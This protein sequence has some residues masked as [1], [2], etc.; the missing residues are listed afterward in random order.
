MRREVG[1]QLTSEPPPEGTDIKF[2]LYHLE[3]IRKRFAE[4]LA[5]RQGSDAS[6]QIVAEQRECV[7]YA[8][9]AVRTQDRL[10][11]ALE[12]LLDAAEDG[13]DPKRALER[14]HEVLRLIR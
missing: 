5:L 4:Q 10:V 7:A 14:G 13:V 3:R 12:G 6:L 2:V 1:R 9:N 8:I 11:E